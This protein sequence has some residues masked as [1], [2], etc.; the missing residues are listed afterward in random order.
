MS[1]D[2][3]TAEFRRIGFAEHATAMAELARSDPLAAVTASFRRHE[4]TLDVA[5]AESR[6]T[7]ACR[8]GC[9][10]CCRYKVD[11]RADEVLAIVEYARTRL[12][13]TTREQVVAAARRNAATIRTLTPREH[14]ASNIACCFLVD[15]RCSIHPAR[16]FACR[17]HHSTD[18]EAC[19]AEYRAAD[20]QTAVPTVPLLRERAGGHREGRQS[21][22]LHAGFDVRAYDLTTAFLEAFDNPA[23]ARRL[24]ARKRALI[25]AIVVD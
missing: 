5:L 6:A 21:A 13:A 3:P 17:N 22:L 12:D 18:V 8:A 23:A 25:A 7:L 11:A 2:E 15:E 16:P 10:W 24:R 4:R 9:A 1:H 19:I 20:G 14:Q